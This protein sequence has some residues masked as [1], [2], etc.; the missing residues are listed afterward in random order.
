MTF[1]RVTRNG[2]FAGIA[3]TGELDTAT[4]P[5]GPEIEKLLARCDP[6]GIE[7]SSRGGPQPDRFTYTLEV[8]GRPVHLREQDLPQELRDL[9]GR[10]L[11]T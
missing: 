9:I 2:G 3:R 1:L 10:M 7:A 8:D 6:A 4:V 11:R 5:D